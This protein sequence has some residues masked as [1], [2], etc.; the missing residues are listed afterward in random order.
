MNVSTP[1][2]ALRLQR[3]R[4]FHNKR[5][6]DHDDRTAQL[7]YYSAIEDGAQKYHGRVAELALGADVLEYGC[8][9]ADNYL[10]LGPVAKSLVAID[11]SDAAISKLKSA[12]HYENVQFH[13]MDAMELELPD[14]SM[15]LVFGSGIVHH[16]DTERSAREVAR[17]LRPGGRAVFWEPLGLNPLINAYRWLTPSAR[18]PDEHPLL[19]GDFEIYKKHFEQVDIQFFGLFTLA[20]VPFRHSASAASLRKVLSGIDKAVLGVSGLRWLGWYSLFEVKR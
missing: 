7:K 13:V 19:P 1:E 20:G 17:V 5:F 4:D 14:Q 2:R 12:N 6:E 16:L 3:E 11:I 18:T 10:R 8:G 15:D 9:D